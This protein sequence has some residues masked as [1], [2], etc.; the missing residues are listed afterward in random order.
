M[1]PSLAAVII[2]SGHH[3]VHV[4]DLNMRGKRDEAI[5]TY[6]ADNGF[7]IITHDLDF[8]RIHAYSGK[9]KPSVILFRIEPL[10]IE[11]IAG[12]LLPNLNQLEADLMKG[13]FV[14]IENE[15][16]RIR[17]LPIKTP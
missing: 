8:S 11:R 6:A 16:I 3:A 7:I 17:E 9:S 13:A 12:L 4:R 15:Q 5:F 10:T 1:P 14:V 2:K